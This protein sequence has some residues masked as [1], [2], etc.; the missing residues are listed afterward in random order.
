MQ[1]YIPG[2]RQLAKR[3]MLVQSKAVLMKWRYSSLHVKIASFEIG[4][5]WWELDQVIKKF[6]LNPSRPVCGAG[7]G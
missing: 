2:V 3:M 1:I 6:Q 7:L 4:L 5:D